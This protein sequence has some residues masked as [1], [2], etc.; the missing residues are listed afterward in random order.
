[1]KTPNQSL[2][3]G[4]TLMDQEQ[5]FP[6]SDSDNGGG[7]KRRPNEK[8]ISKLERQRRKATKINPM[9]LEDLISYW[10]EI[11]DK[12]KRPVISE[13]RK[14]LLCEALHDYGLEYCKTAVLGCSYSD[15]HMGSNKQNITYN[16]LELIFRSPENIE[17][18]YGYAQ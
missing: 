11:M 18:F 17:R 12:K 2:K 5:L 4:K 3:K 8:T 15:F 16:S 14:L 6:T 9:I 13:D 1:L 10:M 7:K